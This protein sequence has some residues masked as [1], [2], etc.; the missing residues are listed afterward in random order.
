MCDVI[1]C[2]FFFFSSNKLFFVTLIQFANEP[3]VKT[4]YIVMH[5][6]SKLMSIRGRVYDAW[7]NIH[8]VLLQLLVCCDFDDLLMLS[9]STLVVLDNNIYASTL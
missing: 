2:L 3:I 6:V 7:Q 5:T 1:V 9:I 8:I 4:A